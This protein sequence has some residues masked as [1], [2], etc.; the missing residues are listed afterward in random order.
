MR[1]IALT[2]DGLTCFRDPQTIDFTGLDVVAIAGPTGAGKSSLLDAIIL[3]LYG[4]VPRMGKQGV[5]ELIAHGRT[6]LVVTFDFAL[7]ADT[8]RVT[9]R[10]N[11]QGRAGQAMLSVLVDGQEQRKAS[12]IEDVKKA[13]RE[14]LGIDAG[15]FTQAVILPQ[16]EFQQFLKA[17]PAA[18][19]RTLN[20][21]LGL[22][23]Y[24]D[25]RQRADGI[26]KRAKIE[27]EQLDRRLEHEWK[28][29]SRI[30]L[31]S[32]ERDLAEVR[33]GL[34]AHEVSVRAEDTRLLR[35]REEAALTAE[36]GALDASLAALDAERTR[37]DELD[38][39]RTLAL[40]VAPV[41]PRLDAAAQALAQRTRA[42]AQRAEAQAALVSAEAQVAALTAARDAARVASAAIEGWREQIADI[43]RARGD[44]ERLAT[45]R[46]ARPN[47]AYSRPLPIFDALLLARARALAPVAGQ[48][49]RVRK[50]LAHEHEALAKEQR[51]ATTRRQGEAQASE[52][53]RVAE[54]AEG[55]ARESWHAAEHEHRAASLRAG[56]VVGE[57]C[58]VCTQQVTHAPP[59]IVAPGLEQ[60][61]A[62]AEQARIAAEGARKAE[63][64]ARAKVEDV[65]RQIDRAQDRVEQHTAELTELEAKLADVP[66]E[67]LA[68]ARL[69]AWSDG[70]EA[71]ERAAIETR[72]VRFGADPARLRKELDD[73]I[74]ASE[75]GLRDAE[76]ALAASEAQR[77]Q[78]GATHDALEAAC[79]AAQAL[80]DEAR[81]AADEA[82]RTLGLGP[83]AARAVA[84]DADTIM[85]IDEQ[86]RAHRDQLLG[87]HQR[88]AAI[89]E[90]LGS[91]RASAADVAGAEALLDQA[92]RALELA[93][94][95]EARLDERVANLRAQ[96]VLAEQARA[97]R[98]IA[99]IEHEVHA[100]L[101]NNLRSDE[102]QAY[103]LEEV[104]RD[105]V[106]GASTRL[107]A[108]SGDRYGLV[109]DDK[110][111]FL[112]VDYDNAGEKRSADTLSGGET[113]LASLALALELSAQIQ[114]K[115]GKIHLES[116]FIDEGFGTLD[117]ETLEVVADAILALGRGQHAR[118]VGLITHVSELSGRMPHKIR[119]ERGPA[120]GG[121]SVRV[122]LGA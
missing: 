76:R 30:T 47:L 69:V 41:L 84:L 93:V 18:R 86:V 65:E 39:R 100:K 34:P 35:L 95:S 42:L 99:K 91:A 107:R 1:P 83:E 90:R 52:A 3:S 74:R 64:S 14:L 8:Y 50:A 106:S 85:A 13:I 79:G 73:R 92:R 32:L 88:R 111:G 120:G 78:A 16:G 25:M 62:A 27:L 87:G 115:A 29:V 21:L 59:A 70:L 6:T 56:L 98:E 81:R 63:L 15:A 102:L 19:R 57:P 43:D 71:A 58:P 51:A 49:E 5:S 77:A 36:L 117:P 31:T 119:V 112:V 68:E 7:G 109:S 104:L 44:V 105:L 67:G 10:V 97:R 103:V 110:S 96:L 55:R 82:L 40:Q 33:A 116:L 20:A 46:Q 37:I 11:R 23:V 72:L 113:F 114:I 54:L 122:E 24:E 101:A 60:A 17:E 61:R 26:A 2:V 108:L 4:V 75:A 94:Q 121:S 80:A 45:L 66:G 9:R 22:G 53:R 48:L 38:E 28:D 12:G 118:M 89:S